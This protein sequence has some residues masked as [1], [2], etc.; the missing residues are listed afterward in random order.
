MTGKTANALPPARGAHQ[1]AHHEPSYTISALAKEFGITTRTIRFYESRG[2]ISPERI[3]TARRYSKRD[4]ARLIL[5]LRGRNLGFT[6][7]D[8]SDYLSLYD[9]DPGHLAQTR[10]LLDKVTA[11]I[12]EIETKRHD[13][14]RS[15]ADLTEIRARCEAHLKKNA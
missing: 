8:V 4:R 13:I 9:S 5:I 2:L 7:E 3:G 11:A 12:A 6:V 1:D 14:E 15:L 10:H